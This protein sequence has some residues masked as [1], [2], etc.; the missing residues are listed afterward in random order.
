MLNLFEKAE[1]KKFAT[2][3][4][5]GKKFEPNTID[6]NTIIKLENQSKIDTELI[7]KNLGLN[8]PTLTY[9]EFAPA[10]KPQ[11]DGSTRGLEVSLFAPVQSLT[12]GLP[13]GTTP[14]TKPPGTTPI[15]TPTGT[16]PTATPGTRQE[17]NESFISKYKM[18][19]IIGA[20]AIGYFF[21]RKK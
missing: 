3:Y 4:T 8:I 9:E 7:R 10:P 16:T 14:I 1:Y 21:L 18:P 6:F 11:N 17:T 19:L 2:F 20:V 15:T 13:P 12:F 5:L